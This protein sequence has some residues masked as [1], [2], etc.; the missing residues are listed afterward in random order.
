MKRVGS[1]EA[2]TVDVKGETPMLTSLVAI[3]GSRAF[4]VNANG[5]ARN[6]NGSNRLLQIS[7]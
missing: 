3:K 4:E 1:G 2:R 7:R 5:I 6:V